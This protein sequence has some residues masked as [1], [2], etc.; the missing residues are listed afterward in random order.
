MLPRDAE[1]LPKF[2]KIIFLTFRLYKR[3]NLIEGC[4]GYLGDCY[5][6]SKGHFKVN[7][8]SPKHNFPKQNPKALTFLYFLSPQIPLLKKKESLKKKVNFSRIS[9]QF[10]RFIFFMVWVIHSWY[11]FPQEVLSNLI[12]KLSNFM[13]FL[14]LRGFLSNIKS[15]M[16]CDFL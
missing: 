13:G 6:Q 15:M 8:H 14:I 2:G 1:Q 9:L 5:I 10:C 11:Y 12:S 4:F 16:S 3:A 7:F